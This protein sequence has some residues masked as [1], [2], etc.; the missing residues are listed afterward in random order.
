MISQ[1]MMRFDRVLNSARKEI[2]SAYSCF[3]HESSQ[4]PG[5]N[6]FMVTS[7]LPSYFRVSVNIPNGLSIMPP[8]A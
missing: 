1:S 2:T 7:R 6:S 3:Q 5:V 4:L 8:P